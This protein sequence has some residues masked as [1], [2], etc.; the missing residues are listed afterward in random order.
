MATAQN[1]Q[2]VPGS[3]F[4]V[5]GGTL[6]IEENDT[7]VALSTTLQQ[8]SSVTANG[9]IPLK[10]TDVILGWELLNTWAYTGTAGTGQT[11]TLSPY[12]PWNLLGPIK[13]NMQNQYN[14]IDVL[15]GRDLAFFLNYRPRWIKQDLEGASALYASP[16]GSNAATG[17]PVSTYTQS[18]LLTGANNSFSSGTPV[19]TTFALRLPASIEFDQYFPLDIAGNLVGQP[20]RAIC[21]PQFMG[22][23]TRIIVPQ[24]TYAQGFGTLDTSPLNT[25]ALT[26]TSDSASTYATASN[27]L[28]I[29]RYGF[30]SSNDVRFLPPVQPWQYALKSFQYP[31]NGQTQ[32]NVPI[33]N[34]AGQLLSLWIWLWDPTLNSG[35][36]GAIAMSNVANCR[37]LYGSSLKRFDD[38]PT[39]AQYRWIQQ[40]NTLPPAGFIGWDMALAPDGRL[41]NWAGVLNTLT[42]NA[43]TVQIQFASGYTPSTTAYAVVGYEALQYVV[44]Q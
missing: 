5:P 24:I 31:I 21:S 37:L 3:L 39:T 44:P 28:T 32:I 19:S 30:Y 8:G 18:A 40:H 2:P 23:T 26:P 38:T 27:A 15:S 17:Y 35:A 14:A 12:W 20:G 1:Q 9:I 42:T 4:G 34:D 29:R 36:G 13:L 11:V 33:P 10:Q 22:G 7:T 16:K 41:M 43:I 25:T 6:P